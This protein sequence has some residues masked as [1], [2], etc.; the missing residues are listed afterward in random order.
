M[1]PIAGK[2][3]RQLSYNEGVTSVGMGWATY[4]ALP[5]KMGRL[6]KFSGWFGRLLRSRW[7]RR[8]AQNRVDQ[9]AQVE[10]R[11]QILPLRV[12]DR[13]AEDELRVID[14]QIFRPVAG[15]RQYDTRASM[16]H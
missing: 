6:L 11:D 5:R 13:M 3:L 10:A 4:V 15:L 12:R 14:Q 8:L 1:V 16:G 2:T 9:L 7:V